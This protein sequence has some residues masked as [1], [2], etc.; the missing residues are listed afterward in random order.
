MGVFLPHSLE[1]ACE[2]LDRVPDAEILAGGTDFMVEVNAGRRR[3]QAVVSLHGVPELTGWRRDGSD[4]VLGAGLTYT[5]MLGSELADLVPCLAQAARTVG[6]PQIRN[7]GTIGGNLGTASPAGDTLPVLAALGA[8]IAV[9]RLGSTRTVTLD[10]LISGPKRT[11]LEPGEIIIDVRLPAGVGTQE[12]L[13]VGP[14][15]AMIIAVANVALVVDWAGR[16]VRAALGSVGPVIIRAV[17]AETFAT[18]RIDWEE[19]R[20]VGGEDALEEF[21][22]LVRAAAHPIDDHRSTADYRR[23]AVGVCARRALER[24]L[25][26]DAIGTPADPFKDE[27]CVS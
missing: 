19:H 13:K 17:E 27:P 12:F 4:V 22:G 1:E 2:L 9:G 18:S 26:H 5:E 20:L 25:R 24:A 8:H 16:R 14:R 3:P 15:N 21:A 6:S 10:E 11:S 7:A 23:H